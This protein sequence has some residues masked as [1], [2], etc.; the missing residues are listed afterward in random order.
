MQ[1]VAVGEEPAMGPHAA[2][3]APISLGDAL[4]LLTRAQLRGVLVALGVDISKARKPRGLRS[5]RSQLLRTALQSR[6]LP[7]RAAFNR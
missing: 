5:L 7:Q 2:T 1:Q 4:K 3:P 6:P